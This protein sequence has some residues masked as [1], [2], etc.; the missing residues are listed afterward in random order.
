M[1]IVVVND[2][3]SYALLFTIHRNRYEAE[4][5]NYMYNHDNSNDNYYFLTDMLQIIVLI[6]AI[7]DKNY[8]G[9]GE[10]IESAKCMGSGQK[11]KKCRKLL[12]FCIVF[13]LFAVSIQ[14][15]DKYLK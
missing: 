1:S 12:I 11:I 2:Q 13:L 15:L 5:S 10:A 6:R 9:G 3:Q 14:N 8:Y 4:W 7:Q